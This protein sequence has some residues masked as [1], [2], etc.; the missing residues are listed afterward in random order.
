MASTGKW[1]E[2]NGLG[3]VV[4]Y[5]LNC[6]DAGTER[7]EGEP[8]RV[9]KSWIF[10]TGGMSWVLVHNFLKDAESKDNIAKQR[11]SGKMRN[12]SLEMVQLYWVSFFMA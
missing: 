4:V 9:L 11:Y 8:Q 12:G 5:W 2:Q 3:G 1:Q 10:V 7:G 6:V